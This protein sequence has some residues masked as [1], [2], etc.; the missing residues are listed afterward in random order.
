MSCQYVNR[1]LNQYV[2]SLLRLGGGGL[3]PFAD[4]EVGALR[5]GGESGE[6]VGGVFDLGGGLGVERRPGI[7]RSGEG[8]NPRFAGTSETARTRGGGAGAAVGALREGGGGAVRAGEGGAVCGGRGG[9]GGGALP[10]PATVVDL[11]GKV[12]VAFRGG[13]AG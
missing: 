9:G 3:L 11:A 6:L 4:V 8:D 12:G 5:G 2:R 1:S 7:A 13:I 10:P